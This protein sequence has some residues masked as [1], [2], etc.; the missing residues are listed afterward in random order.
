MISEISF[1]FG[2]LAGLRAA[3]V[4]HFRIDNRLDDAMA[5]VL[6]TIEADE[7][8][9]KLETI[10][11][12]RF[13]HRTVRDMI[14]WGTHGALLTLESPGFNSVRLSLRQRSAERRLE[15]SDHGEWFRHLG[16]VFAE[17]L[18]ETGCSS[19]N[20]PHCGQVMRG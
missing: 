7:D 11:L 2:L 19:T 5:K 6:D 12:S 1:H 17:H 9:P 10:A 16:Q 3:G 18:L 13:A 4:S 20:C 8:S 14:S 15:N